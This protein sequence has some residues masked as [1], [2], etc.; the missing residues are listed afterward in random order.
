[1]QTHKNQCK[2]TSAKCVKLDKPGKMYGV[3][4]GVGNQ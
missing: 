4:F 1:M 2:W 3:G